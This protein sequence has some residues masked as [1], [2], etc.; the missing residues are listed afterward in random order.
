MRAITRKLVSSRNKP[1]AQSVAEAGNAHWV[2]KRRTSPVLRSGPPAG[3]KNRAARISELI[4][5]LRIHHSRKLKLLIFGLIGGTLLL[6]CAAAFLLSSDDIYAGQGGVP[7]PGAADLESQLLN[8]LEPRG[9]WHLTEEARTINP[10]QFSSLELSEYTIAKGDT[11]SEIAKKFGLKMDTL[12]SFNQINNVRKMQVGTV[13]KIPNRDGLM[14]RVKRGDSLSAISARNSISI[15]ALLDAN[16]LDSTELQI[17]QDLFLPGARM[18]P[19]ELRLAIQEAFARPVLG[20][21]TSNY[22]MRNDPFTGILRFHNGVDLAN[23]V[24]TPIYAAMDGVVKRVETQLGYYGK[25]VIIGHPNGYQTLYAHLNSFNVRVG[26][27]VSR[28]QKIGEMGNTGRS[29][30]PHLH[31]SIFQNGKSIN[32]LDQI[33]NLY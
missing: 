32:P 14:Y 11:L 21:F 6:Y 4:K 7:F 27:Q 8:Y 15:N 28:G 19:Y 17:G 13:L 2:E 10:E 31:F 1:A 9:E 25:Y 30:G 18:D 12:I 26:Q 16:D 22:G 5:G 33:P 3:L 24:G 29:T 23:A 20:R